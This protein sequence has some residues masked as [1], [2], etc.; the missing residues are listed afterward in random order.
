EQWNRTFG[1]K[2]SDY[3]YYVEQ[4]ADDGYIIKGQTSSYGRGDFDA[5]LIKTNAKGIEQWNKTFGGTFQ[6]STNFVK[7]TPDGGF[8]LAGSRS[9]REYG[10]EAWIIRTDGKGNLQWMKP[11][12]GSGLGSVYSVC[13]TKDNGFVL[14]GYTSLYRS[15]D[16]YAWLIRTGGWTN[17]TANTTMENMYG[18]SPVGTMSLTTGESATEV[19]EENVSGFEIVLAIIAFSAFLVFGRKRR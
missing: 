9:Y 13:T 10:Y 16:S 5:W 11:F 4:T 2:G 7:Q 1:G 3:A 8:I 19:P 17:G 18:I 14:A 6:D 12:R 15:T